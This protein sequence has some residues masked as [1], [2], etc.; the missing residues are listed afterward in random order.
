MRRKGLWILACA[1][2]LCMAGCRADADKA[3]KQT[4]KQDKYSPIVAKGKEIDEEA[5]Y[6]YEIKVNRREN[7]VTVYAADDTGKYIV[8]VRSM[9]CSVG[10]D[11]PSGTF[12][13]GETSRWQMDADDTFS[14]YATRIVDDVVFHSAPY[15]SMNNQDLD[16]EQFNRMGNEVDG[17][18][19]QLE[20]A[21]AKWIAGNCPEGTKVEICDE[22]KDVPLGKPQA[23]RLDEDETADP[24]DNGK[25]TDKSVQYV[26]VQFDGISDM[27]VTMNGTCSLMDGV[28]A[29]D[30][31]K[32]DLTAYVQVYGNVDVTTP[33]VYKVSYL[34][35][36]DEEETRIVEREIEVVSQ[37]T[38]SQEQ[39]ATVF[40]YGDTQPVTTQEAA[41]TTAPEPA[42]SE[43]AAPAGQEVVQTAV[44]QQ[45]VTT[46]VPVVTE[47]PQVYVFERDVTPPDIDIVAET[48]YTNSLNDETLRK[49]VRISDNSGVVE[50]L[51]VTVQ[52]LR[53]SEYYVVVYEAVDASGN[54]TCIS[55]MVKLKPDTVFSTQN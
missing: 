12:Q 26:P 32:K 7:C 18:S 8:P 29:Y 21:D 55:E 43:S 6:P 53:Q 51:Y 11:T 37:D 48:R 1:G 41:E 28:T 45:P 50:H 2:V 3:D 31:D 23:R 17:Q 49:R 27:T 14:Q 13:L 40:A 44:Q 33:G 24:T 30:K 35:T 54:S 22:D 34:C 4:E 20:V 19:V 5:E 36:N 9:I 39:A 25:K 52:G 15:Y 38:P 10:K 46:P 16:V 42:V 47:P